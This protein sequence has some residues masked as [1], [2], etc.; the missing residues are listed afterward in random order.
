MQG[1]EVG[2]RESED[3][4][5]ATPRAFQG[6]LLSIDA[7]GCLAQA[8][9]PPLASPSCQPR[10]ALMSWVHDTAIFAEQATAPHPNE[11]LFAM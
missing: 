2:V 8:T 7:S 3:S 6:H 11:T 4:K 5:H 1:R 9:L 10:S